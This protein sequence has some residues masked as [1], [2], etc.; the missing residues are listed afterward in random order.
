MIYR[1]INAVFSSLENK[2]IKESFSDSEFE[3]DI[4]LDEFSSLTDDILFLK[5]TYLI[6]YLI[7]KN[8]SYQ[9]QKENT[10]LFRVLKNLVVLDFT[11]ESCECGTKY[12]RVKI[13]KEKTQANIDSC[14]KAYIDNCKEV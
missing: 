4:F 11:V 8:C 12:Y 10:E 1:D 7:S 9:F 6:S 13:D 14:F 2:H 3:A 5:R